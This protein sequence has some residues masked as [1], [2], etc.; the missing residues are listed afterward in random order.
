[1]TTSEADIGRPAPGGG[2][3]PSVAFDEQHAHEAGFGAYFTTH[4]APVL[5]MVEDARLAARKTFNFRLLICLMAAI[6]VVAAGVLFGPSLI[7]PDYYDVAIGGAFVAVVGAGSWI[8][9]PRT[10]FLV[11]F[12]Q[13]IL[14]PVA[15][16]FNLNFDANGRDLCASFGDTGILHSHDERSHEDGFWGEYQGVE[17][18]FE[19]VK[20]IKVTRTKR[21][22]RRTTTFDGVAVVLRMNKR[23]NGH[24]IIKEDLGTALNW[25]RDKTSK[26]ETVQLEDPRFE[27]RFEVFS[28]DQVEA[29]YLLTP[30]FMERLLSVADAFDKARLRACFRDDRLYLL[31]PYG[32]NLFEAASL[33]KTVLETDSLRKVLRQIQ[34]LRGTVEDLKLNER[35]GL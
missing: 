7:P 23:F 3:A 5:G 31:I 1:V 35:L 25:I 30:A 33:H 13:E 8:N 20:L 4:I 2:T 32:Q 34:E 21:G 29:R 15:T 14:R 16:F 26:L 12:K 6:P 9:R 10:K 18:A 17:L 19:E 27:D 28:S 11:G 24:T 22:T